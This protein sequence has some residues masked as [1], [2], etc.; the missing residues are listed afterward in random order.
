MDTL[1]SLNMFNSVDYLAPR[2][3]ECG[4]EIEYG[5][6]TKFDDELGTHVCLKCN[7]PL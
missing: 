1:N 6:T 7:K 4:N 3:K 5:V 2:C